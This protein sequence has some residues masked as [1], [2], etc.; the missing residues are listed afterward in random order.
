MKLLFLII[1]IPGILCANNFMTVSKDTL[2]FVEHQQAAMGRDIEMTCEW[3]GLIVKHLQFTKHSWARWWYKTDKSLPCMLSKDPLKITIGSYLPVVSSASS[4]IVTDSLIIQTNFDTLTFIT[5]YFRNEIMEIKKTD[6]MDLELP[7]DLPELAVF[8]N[9]RGQKIYYNP[10][11]ANIKKYGIGPAIYF[12]GGKKTLKMK[13]GL[14][15][16][17]LE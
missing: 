15:I 2:Y 9:V 7:S 13:D 8:Y 17:S 6:N 12:S 1:F 11:T 14:I 10:L 5:L 3:S 4:G 16:Y